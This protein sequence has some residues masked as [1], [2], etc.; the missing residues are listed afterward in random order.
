MQTLSANAD[1]YKLIMVE[2]LFL[3]HLD[4]SELNKYLVIFGAAKPPL[5]GDKLTFHPPPQSPPAR[6][7]SEDDIVAGWP[8]GGGGGGG[9]GGCAGI[10]ITS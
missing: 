9:G 4:T 2:H 8:A 3:L 6:T 7:F 5:S 1:L 10:S